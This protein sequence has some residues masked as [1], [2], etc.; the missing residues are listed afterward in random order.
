V[1]FSGRKKYFS[2]NK[3]RKKAHRK[4]DH[5]IRREEECGA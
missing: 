5:K 1:R 2:E 3:A 4:E